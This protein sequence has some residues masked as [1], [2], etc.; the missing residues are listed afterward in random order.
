MRYLAP[1]SPLRPRQ[2]SVFHKTIKGLRTLERRREE[3]ELPLLSLRA[4]GWPNLENCCD[5]VK[6]MSS[7]SA[8]IFPMLSR[9]TAS[10]TTAAR[11]NWLRNMNWHLQPV[12]PPVDAELHMT[13]DACSSSAGITGVYLAVLAVFHGRRMVRIGVATEQFF[14]EGS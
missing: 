11:A 8:L 7:R 6:L 3:D 14:G 4:A 1:H 12:A 9:T 5:E 2:F 13:D 10:A